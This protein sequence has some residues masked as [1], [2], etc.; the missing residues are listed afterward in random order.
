MTSSNPL[1][2]FLALSLVA[3]TGVTLAACA[4]D[5]ESPADPVAADEGT[6]EQDV[7]ARVIGEESN[8][9]TVEV[10]LGRP[11]TVALADNSASSGY[12]WI[13]KS[14]DKTIGA[15][16][17]S[18]AAP[19][20][21]GPIGGKGTRKFAWKTSSPLNLVGKHKITFI[22]QRP[23]AETSPPAQT[24][25]VTI[26]IKD[27]GPT[28]ATCGGL[29]GFQCKVPNTYCQ[30]TA[31]Q[32]CG[33]ADQMG[34]CQIKPDACTAQYLPVCGCDGNTYSNACMANAAGTSVSKTGACN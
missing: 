13:V 1:V 22:L 34:T 17:E 9:K 10:Q 15:P 21:N 27:P 33:A 11:F 29:A 28:V 8:N 19:P 16:K 23:W 20:K 32:L 26:D 2:R 14:V 3:A 6:D 24:F 5:T 30:Y 12:R 25:T 7:T 18:Y 4:A 31:A